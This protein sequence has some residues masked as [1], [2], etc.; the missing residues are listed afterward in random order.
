MPRQSL[1]PWRSRRRP[2]ASA[3]VSLIPSPTIATTR[4]WACSLPNLLGLVLGKYLGQHVVRRECRPASDRLCGATVVARD[5]VDGD[6]HLGEALN[7]LP[8]VVLE[9]VRDGDHTLAG[10]PSMAVSMTVLPSD[11]RL[12]ILSVYGA[13]VDAL[14]NHELAIAEH[15]PMPFNDAFDAVPRDSDEPGNVT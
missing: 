8:G 3:G 7:R 2:F 10:L 13:R 12:S 6:A 14:A 1:R 9:R 4:P 15:H 11:S 5:H